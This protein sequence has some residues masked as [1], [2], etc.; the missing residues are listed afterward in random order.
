[1]SPASIFLQRRNKRPCA[2]A[3]LPR[4]VSSVRGRGSPA[5]EK[6]VRRSRPVDFRQG[7]RV[8]TRV[9]EKPAAFQIDGEDCG[10]VTEFSARIK[11]RGLTVRVAH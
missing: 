4:F 11:R 10:T 1:M 5:E 3:G 2:A 9:L 6:E 8:H 7:T